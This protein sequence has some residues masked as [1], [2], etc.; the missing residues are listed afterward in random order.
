M[1]NILHLPNFFALINVISLYFQYE[2]YKYNYYL[3]AGVHRLVLLFAFIWLLPMW[4]QWF[5][6]PCTADDS[7]DLTRRNSLATTFSLLSLFE[8]HFK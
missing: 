8:W 4:N 6:R 1:D 2:I 7:T 5:D 3:L